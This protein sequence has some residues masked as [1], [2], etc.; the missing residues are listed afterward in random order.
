MAQAML[1]K[2]CPSLGNLSTMAERKRF[3]GEPQVLADTMAPHLA[4]D[5]LKYE[6]SERVQAKV[7][8]DRILAQLPLLGALHAVQGNLMFARKSVCT[9]FGILFDDCGAAWGLKRCYRDEWTATM[10]N[11]LMNLN[12]AVARAERANKA[13]WLSQLPWRKL[14]ASPPAAGFIYGWDAEHKLAWRTA[15]GQGTAFKELCEKVYAPDGAAPEDP[16]RD[17]H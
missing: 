9:A 11:R 14:A 12:A 13:K 15:V 2:R 8:V 1:P 10:T 17:R 16:T 7:D 5:S 3:P 6:E 4:K